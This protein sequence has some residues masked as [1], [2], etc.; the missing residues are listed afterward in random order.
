MA[1]PPSLLGV[2]AAS[3]ATDDD[4]LIMDEVLAHQQRSRH[5]IQYQA[6]AGTTSFIDN[7]EFGTLSSARLSYVLAPQMCSIHSECTLNV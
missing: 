5:P 7:N 1:P 6:A 4:V 2:L 3:A